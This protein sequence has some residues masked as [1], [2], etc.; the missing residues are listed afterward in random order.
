MAI[1]LAGGRAGGLGNGIRKQELTSF[2]NRAINPL[3]KHGGGWIMEVPVHEKYMLSI[4]EASQYF[5][6]G[7]KWLRRFAEGHPEIAMM[8]GDKWRILRVK[9]EEYLVNLPANEKG[10]KQLEDY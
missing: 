5:G 4:L 7:A 2:G 10:E 1:V 9:M 6:L 3:E 8:H